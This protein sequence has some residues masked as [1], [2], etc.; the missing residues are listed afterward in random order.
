MGGGWGGGGGGYRNYPSGNQARALQSLQTA[1]GALQPSEMINRDLQFANAPANARAVRRAVQL[2]CDAIGDP[3]LA[4]RRQEPIPAALAP[5]GGGGLQ[6]SAPPLGDPLLN[7][8]G[9]R[10]RQQQGQR[11]AKAA[12]FGI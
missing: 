12:C 11:L 1:I 9:A 3:G 8:G 2:M 6:P 7:D 5:G 10:Q 4:T